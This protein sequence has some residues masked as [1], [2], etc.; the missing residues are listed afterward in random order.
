MKGIYLVLL[1]LAGL[2][3]CPGNIKEVKQE[4]RAVYKVGEL[5]NA[6]GIGYYE[7]CKRE[8]SNETFRCP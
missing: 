6:N 4:N 3:G 2:T 7:A 1:F 8:G 5:P